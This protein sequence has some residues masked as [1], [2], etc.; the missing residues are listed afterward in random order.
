MP[1]QNECPLSRPQ[2]PYPHLRTFVR[3]NHFLVIVSEDYMEDRYIFIELDSIDR[4]LVL[5]RDGEHGFLC[6]NVP[7][8][9]LFCS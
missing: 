4:S 3:T 5:S 6:F 2:V 1:F 7:Q 8:S 9:A